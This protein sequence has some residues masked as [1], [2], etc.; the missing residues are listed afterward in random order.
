MTKRQYYVID[1]FATERFQGNPAA[2]VLDAD[3]LEPATMQAIAAEFNLSE[4]TFVLPPETDEAGFRFRWFTP[5]TEVSMCGHATVAGALA[6]C[7]AGRIERIGNEDVSV[8][9]DSRSGHLG[10]HLES[11]PRQ[12]MKR[13]IWLD[14]PTPRLTNEDISPDKLAPMLGLDIDSFDASLPLVRTQEDDVLLFVNDVQ[15]VND[16]RPDF[17]GLKDFQNERRMRGLCVSTVSTI[18]PSIHT[19]SRFFAPAAGVNED[20]VTGSV[21]G[22]LCAYLVMQGRVALTDGLA[23]LQC[24]QGIPGGRSGV[25]FALV[26]PQGDGRHEVRIGGQAHIVMKG[27]ILS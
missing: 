25:I 20:P 15:A 11:L 27:T 6:L 13:M 21:H 12:P 26:Q 14:M 23:A 9:V 16:A 7:D 3:G 22:P 8:V 4:T 1:A 2:V 19:Q 24:V 18:T 10:L 5:T 17:A